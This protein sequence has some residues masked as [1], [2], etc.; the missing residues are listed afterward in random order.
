MY[1]RKSIPLGTWLMYLRKSRQ[2]NPDETVAEVLAKH[3]V[4]LQ[5][6]ALRELGFRIPEENIYREV[7]S[8]ESIDE[9]EEIKKVLARIEDPSVVGVLVIEP[10]RLSRGDLEDCG[11]LIN[12]FRFTRTLVIT[13]IITYDLGNKMERKFFQDELL[14]G[15]DY[16]EY[17]KEILSRGRIAAIKRG[18][19]IG[20]VPPYGYDK[21]KIGK[22]NTL[23]PNENADVVR[24][25]FDLCANQGLSPYSIALQLND[26]AIPAPK[27]G[28]WDRATI[29]KILS[30]LHYIGKV[31]FN[32]IKSTPVLENGEIV[33]KRLLQPAEEV[34][35]AEG[36]HPA[37]IEKEVWD[38][39]QNRFDLNPPVKH[40]YPLKNPFSGLLRCGKCGRAMFSHPY[41]HADTR[42]EC[43]SI[44]R[45]YKSVKQADVINGVI[46]V[47]EEVEIPKLEL[48][49]KNRDGDAAKIQQG[50]LSK[51]EKQ[52]EDYR[53]QEDKQFELLESGTYTEEIFNRRHH[54]LLEKMALCQKQIL[55]TKQRM[56]KSVDYSERLATLHDAIAALKDPDAVAIDQNR[57]IKKIISRID[58]MG[59][60]SAGS[61]QTG[62][63][64]NENNFTVK[65]TLV[66]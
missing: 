58:F 62:T 12:A 18:C 49:I 52:L 1:E 24:T 66:I 37:I 19:Y 9:R 26:M 30:N 43:R 7:K 10:Q 60:K 29:R 48:K 42:M 55:E 59:Q 17:T 61:D 47:L 27:G 28:K 50:L 35:I 46:F 15:R 31:A 2:D 23:V 22:D 38:K 54:A 64:R 51:Y 21:I 16:L 53:N 45:C 33:H 6:H 36:K 34:T 13:P 65:V 39:V 3:E 32:Q 4:Q 5:D 8:G 56:P 11:H 63:I 57:T 25:I 40:A 14:R 20:N 44:P 41:K